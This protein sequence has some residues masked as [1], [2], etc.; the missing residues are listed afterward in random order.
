LPKQ[1]ESNWLFYGIM[2]MTVHWT[3]AA[4]GLV[5]AFKHLGSN[6]LLRIQPVYNCITTMFEKQTTLRST[7]QTLS[8]RNAKRVIKFSGK[9][10]SNSEE[11]QGFKATKLTPPLST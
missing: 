6:I 9:W 10:A 11:M 7:V 2:C 4:C 3:G 8:P 1:I 5:R